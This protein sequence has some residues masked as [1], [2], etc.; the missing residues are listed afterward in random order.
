MSDQT[1]PVATQEDEDGGLSDLRP[2]GQSGQDEV[3]PAPVPRPAQTTQ[4][5]RK[6]VS[7]D[8]IRNMVASVEQRAV[9]TVHG[10]FLDPAD[11]NYNPA[12]DLPESE[13]PFRTKFAAKRYHD[14]RQS[15]SAVKTAIALRFLELPARSGDDA[16]EVPVVLI[17][18]DKEPE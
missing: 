8:D 5:L 18:P 4:A 15:E 6:P 7:V 13:V 2:Q 12:G 16:E 17:E 3:R 11:P 10:M 1:T 14:A 9:E